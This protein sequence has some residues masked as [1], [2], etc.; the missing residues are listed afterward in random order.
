MEGERKHNISIY[1]M[2]QPVKIHDKSNKEEITD[3]MLKRKI[4]IF[5]QIGVHNANMD[6]MIETFKA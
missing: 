3:L 5:A 4:K 6:N 2:F 1:V